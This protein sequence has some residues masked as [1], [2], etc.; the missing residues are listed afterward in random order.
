[1]ATLTG[2]QVNND[3]KTGYAV[4]DGFLGAPSSADIAAQRLSTQPALA[5]NGLTGNVAGNVTGT[6]TTVAQQVNAAGTN[7]Q[8]VAT[9]VVPGVILVVRATLTSRAIRLSVAATNAIYEVF[10][11]LTTNFKVYPATNAAIRGSATNAAVSIAPNKGN[12]FVYRSGVLI[13]KM[14]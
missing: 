7:Q 1:M 13:S 3:A 10:N 8:S 12:I 2:T 5:P 6:V 11:A 9:P 4:A 14:I